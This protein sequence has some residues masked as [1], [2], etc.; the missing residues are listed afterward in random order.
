M[1]RH[2][3]A[4][5]AGPFA[6]V[7]RRVGR[8]WL[9]R[10]ARASAPLIVLLGLCALLGVANPNFLSTANLIRILSLAAVPLVLALGVTFVILLGSIDLSVEGVM[11]VGA[12]VLGLFVRND[13]N[14]LDL[15][16][17]V[18][19]AAILAG[20]LIGALN[21]VLHVG[22]RIPSFMVTLGTWF[23]SVGLATILLGGGTVRVLDPD[24]RA[25]ALSRFAGLPFLV[26]IAAAMLLIAWVIQDHTRLGRYAYAIGGGE[27]LAALSGIPI[28]RVRIAVFA[29]A[30]A[31]YG[32]GGALAVAQ[33]GQANAVIGEGRL[34]TMITAVVVGGTSLMGGEGGVLNTL[35]G[36]LIVAVLANGMVLLGI[37]PYVQQAVQGLMII[38]A[39]AASLDRAR[40][41]IVK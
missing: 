32:L 35:I 27:D 11:A 33:L 40:A 16:P 2:G 23:A 1:D 41:Q 24:V 21:G 26:W 5:T 36:V 34:F 13:A 19:L 14:A 25:L 3:A 6:A 30:G 22:L 12:I 17:G 28:T 20:V 9:R 38:A 7:T 10:R 4:V 18:V 15:G 31:F 39:V 37:S 8:S 29:L